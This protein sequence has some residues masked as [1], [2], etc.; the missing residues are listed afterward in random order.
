[1]PENTTLPEIMKRARLPHRR[2]RLARL[3]ERL[4]PRARRRRLRQL[5]RQD[6]DPYRVAADK[7][8]DHVARVD[9]AAAGQ[10]VVHVGALHRSARPLRRAP[11][12]RRLRLRRTTIST[13][14]SCK[15]TDQEVGRL[16]DEL[17]R[18]PSYENTIIIITSD[19]GESM[20]EHNV[21][22]GTHGTALYRELHPRAA[23]LLH[24]RQPAAR[25][26]AAP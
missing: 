18:L 25:R 15:W 20:G 1:M 12:R 21:P 11:R 24:P 4:G 22:L 8:T 23:D 2:D 9:L 19:H 6:A 7:V 17:R 10:Q 13:T 3:V 26:S 5:D 16:L 14:P